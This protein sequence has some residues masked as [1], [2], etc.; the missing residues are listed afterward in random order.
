MA[1]G[2]LSRTND[3]PPH[4]ASKSYPRQGPKG[5]TGRLNSAVGLVPPGNTSSGIIQAPAGAQ[6]LAG[7]L[8]VPPL[9]PHTLGRQ[10]QKAKSIFRLQGAKSSICKPRAASF[11]K[12][13]AAGSRTRPGW[14]VS[15][16]S[17]WA[18]CR[19][20][21]RSR[22]AEGPKGRR[23]FW[24]APERA[25]SEPA[26]RTRPASYADFWGVRG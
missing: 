19:A 5:I 25:G 8:L 11:S 2:L 4:L 1:S 26:C 9:K 12:L 24:V 10:L 7:F 22:R 18:L 17:W 20:A 21:R 6:Q 3:R 16:S 14:G 13:Q 23:V 15:A